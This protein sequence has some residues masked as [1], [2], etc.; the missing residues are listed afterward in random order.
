MGVLSFGAAAINKH[1]CAFAAL[2]GVALSRGV[3]AS[4]VSTRLLVEKQHADTSSLLTRF[5]IFALSRSGEQVVSSL[6]IT[7]HF[8][9]HRQENV[10]S[11]GEEGLPA[12]SR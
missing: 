9:D 12:A 6:E 4:L 8:G 10:V 5:M 2:G 3:G 11:Y 1:S 7:V